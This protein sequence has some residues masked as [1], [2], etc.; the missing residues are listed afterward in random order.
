MK[1]SLCTIVM[2]VTVLNEGFFIINGY[3]QI[4]KFSRNLNYTGIQE[5][6]LHIDT[7]MMHIVIMMNFHYY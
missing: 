7:A 1:L 6:F 5:V 2:D 4:K 3:K